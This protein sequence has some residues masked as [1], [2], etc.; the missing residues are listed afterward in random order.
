VLAVR[1]ICSKDRRIQRLAD[2]LDIKEKE[3]EKMLEKLDREQRDFFK[4]AFN[5]KDASAYEF[6]IVLNCDFISEPQ[7]AAE[8]VAGTY[9]QKFGP[10]IKS[11]MPTG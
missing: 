9:K 8:I 2:L 10:E 7:Q 1:F 5:K 4:K 3:A 11:I 6:D